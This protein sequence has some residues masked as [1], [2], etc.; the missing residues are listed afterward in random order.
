MKRTI[1]LSLFFY[2]LSLI[3]SSCERL[4]EP[5]GRQEISLTI[6]SAEV[7]EVWLRLKV[8]PADS[9]MIYTVQRDTHIVFNDALDTA[10][11]LLHDENLEPANDYTYHAF[12]YLNGNR[13]K[14]E[15]TVQTTTMD[16]TSHNFTWQTYEFGEK[17]SSAFYDVAIINEND[18]WAVGEIYTKDSYTYDSLGNWIDPYN[19]A[20]WDGEKW[21]LKRLYFNYNDSKMWSPIR[22]ILAFNSDDIWFEG[23]YWNGKAYVFKPMNIDFPYQ[24]NKMWGVSSSDYYIVGNSGA[25]AHYNGKSWQKIESVTNTTIQDIWGI[26]D[27]SAGKYKILCAASPGYGVANSSILQINEN[28]TVEPIPWISGRAVRSVWF[29]DPSFIYTCGSGILKRNPYGEWKE[30]GGVDVIPAS[31]ERIRGIDCNDIFIVGHFGYITH[32]NGYNFKVIRP[33]PVI[34]Y[35]SC[36]Y[37]NNL[38]IAV[39]Y[40][41][42]TAFIV[43]IRR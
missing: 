12:R 9:R 41:G 6:E 1:L 38:M 31:T 18:I 4:T 20:H 29:N 8:E 28:M 5:L 16:T 39:G 33:N 21:E 26:Y 37:K 27:Y 10:D 35:E 3:F 2:L 15:V 11:T 13:L 22:T 32:Y 25:I 14:P 19:A 30:I 34:L 36:D 7:T 40:D 43:H 23:I 24:V 42:R 17:S